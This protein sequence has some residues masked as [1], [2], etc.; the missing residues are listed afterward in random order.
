MNG[1]TTTRVSVAE[2]AA[3]AGAAVAMETFRTDI[4]IET[5]RGKTD[6]VAE[7][8]RDAQRRVF[9]IIERA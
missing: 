8:D 7:A 1:S 5:K 4:E 9:E 6:P 2:R 3:K